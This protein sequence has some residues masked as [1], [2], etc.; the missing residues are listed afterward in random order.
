MNNPK[1]TL[2]ESV[3]V[4]LKNSKTKISYMKLVYYILNKSSLQTK[5]NTK[6]SKIKKAQKAQRSKKKKKT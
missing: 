1:Q 3:E 4:F 2:S 5:Q 6:T